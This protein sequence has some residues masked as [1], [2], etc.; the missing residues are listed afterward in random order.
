V[1]STQRCGSIAALRWRGRFLLLAKQFAGRAIDEMKP[2]AG[3]ADHGF[4]VRIARRGFVQP[5]LHVHAGARTFED[6]IA[7]SSLECDAC[8]TPGIDLCQCRSWRAVGVPSGVAGGQGAVRA[9]IRLRSSSTGGVPAI[10]R[11]R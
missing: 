3:N 9:R 8:S 10:T 6:K 11:F 4:I 5:M 2:A 1:P 7:H